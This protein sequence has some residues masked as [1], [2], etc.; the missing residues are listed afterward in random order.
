MKK[1]I[2]LLGLMVGIL[3]SGTAQTDQRTR[4]TKIADIVM[5]LPAGNTEILN[6]LMGELIELGDVVAYLAPRLTDGDDADLQLRYAISGLAMYASQNN[7]KKELVA[8][9][10][11]KA[12]T[13]AKS[14]EIRD[15]LMIQLQYVAGDES[16]ET[17]TSY[18]TNTRLSDAAARVLVRIGSD[19]AGT[20]L[21]T[22]LKT[23]KGA[24]Q[25][26]IIEA[27][28]EMRYHPAYKDISDFVA[29]S[30]DPK[31][32]KAMWR[33]L[34]LIAHPSSEKMLSQVAKAVG[35]KFEPTDAFGSYMLFLH[36]S[37]PAQSAMVAKSAKNML[38]ATSESSQLAAKTAALELLTLSAGEKAIGDVTDALKSSNKQY[39]QAALK[40]S[41]NIQSP[42]MYDALMKFAKKEKRDEVEAEIVAAF[43]VRG[44]KAAWPFV[45]E[46]L[47]DDNNYVRSSAIGAAGKIA[48]SDA[49]ALIVKAMNSD[50][51]HVVKAGKNTLLSIAGE[52]V[53]TQAAAAIP[54]A[55]VLAKVAFLEIL[56]A[57]QAAP[58]AQA[59]FN[60]TSSTDPQVRL[61][62]ATALASVVTE[63][64]VPRIAQLLN[65]ASNKEET[66]ALQAAMYAAVSGLNQNAQTD[67][68]MNQAMMS[69]RP[70]VYGNVFAMIGGKRA[71]DLVME[72]G[73]NSGY[74]AFEEIAFEALL[75][76]SD[77]LAIEQ[78]YKIAVGTPSGAFF[79]RA[80]SA[81]ITKTGSSRNTPEQKLL[82]LRNAL[83]IAQ[84]TTHK[85]AILRQ[86][87]RTGTFIGMV[88]AG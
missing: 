80:L 52:E 81:Y 12:I 36:N 82:M 85:Q 5:L 29:L 49:V 2:I 42:K 57:R 76:W 43:G 54:E 32:H 55:T 62:A 51:M 69:N 46:C 48:G 26:T 75:N 16:V 30:G 47:T 41:Q 53:V 39:R 31:M 37:L 44:D 8:S 23:S 27:L 56:A 14:D 6:R 67:M 86:I 38:K 61:A 28:G 84:S 11:C 1:T 88:T 20:A 17:A 58:F 64:E 87:G 24:Q 65:N 22:A 68:V 33:S 18:L 70:E 50:D 40:F 73:F 9:S 63:K 66:N 71:L 21:M 35:Y 15:F 74:A 19:K 59:I 25:I 83:E 60:Q 13:T 3:M 72:F 79:D 10:L 45:Q 78:L 77:A 34:A 4:E 7:D